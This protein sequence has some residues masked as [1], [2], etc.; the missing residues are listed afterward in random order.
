V[1]GLLRVAAEPRG[2]RPTR[3]PAPHRLAHLSGMP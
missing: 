2:R 1:A 3:R